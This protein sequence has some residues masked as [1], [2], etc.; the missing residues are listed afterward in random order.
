VSV[1]DSKD[2]KY[3]KNIRKV[4][5]TYLNECQVGHFKLLGNTHAEREVEDD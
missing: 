2:M 3:R 4:L 5:L 1:G